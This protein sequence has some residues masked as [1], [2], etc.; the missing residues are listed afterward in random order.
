VGAGVIASTRTSIQMQSTTIQNN[1][2]AGPGTGDGIRI[3]LGSALFAQA[4]AGTVTGTRDSPAVQRRRV[5]RVPTHH[6]PTPR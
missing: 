6:H 4:P 5:E 1:V 2:A 3:L